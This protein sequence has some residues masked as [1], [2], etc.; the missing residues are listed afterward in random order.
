MSVTLDTHGHAI[1]G[2]RRTF[3]RQLEVLAD[4]SREPVVDLT[5]PPHH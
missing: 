3:R 4:L 5:V 2:V 1:A